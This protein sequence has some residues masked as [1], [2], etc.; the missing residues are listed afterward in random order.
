MDK[1]EGT[2]VV[3]GVVCSVFSW[4]NDG[5]EFLVETRNYFDSAGAPRRRVSSQTTYGADGEILSRVSRLWTYSV[6][7]AEQDAEGEAE[8][9]ESAEP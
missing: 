3:D 7:A 6:R 8:A 1:Y 5:G 9:R 2:E 4:T